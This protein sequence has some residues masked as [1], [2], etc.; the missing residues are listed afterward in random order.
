MD[1]LLKNYYIGQVEN[2]DFHSE[3]PARIKIEGEQTKTK[4][5][6]LNQLSAQIIVETLIKE[7]NLKIS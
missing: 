3:Y 4:W 1:K 7:F 2:I 6:D 5:M